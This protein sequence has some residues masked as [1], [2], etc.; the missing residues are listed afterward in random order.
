MPGVLQPP[1]IPHQTP[2]PRRVPRTRLHRA[3]RRANTR[4]KLTNPT[5]KGHEI[6]D[7]LAILGIIWFIWMI[8]S[9]NK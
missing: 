5:T 9:M 7:L 4:A 8:W 3:R 6:M 1:P 2:A